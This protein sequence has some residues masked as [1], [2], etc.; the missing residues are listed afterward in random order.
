MSVQQKKYVYANLLNGPTIY[1]SIGQGSLAREYANIARTYIDTDSHK[2]KQVKI[3]RPQ[4]RVQQWNKTTVVQ[5][6]FSNCRSL[7]TYKQFY[8]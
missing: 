8:K 5:F 1:R 4:I 2:L 3:V 6:L 7:S